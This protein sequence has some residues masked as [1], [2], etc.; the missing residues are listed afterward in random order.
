MVVDTGCRLRG[1]RDSCRVGGLRVTCSAMAT[2]VVSVRRRGNLA[3]A[4]ASSLTLVVTVTLSS[5]SC[6]MAGRE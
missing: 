2:S 5:A 4:S 1:V 3:F 6:S